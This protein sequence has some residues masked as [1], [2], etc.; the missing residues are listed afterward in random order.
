[1]NARE[2]F[3]APK[4]T[5]LRDEDAGL[6]P[7]REKNGG[8]NG[9]GG[10]KQRERALTS[11]LIGQVAHFQEMLFASR[12]QKLLLILQGMDTSGKDGTTRALFSESQ[13]SPMGL[14]ATGFVAPTE[15]ER[16][17]DFLWRVHAHVP[18]NG[19]IAVF[20]RSHY[21]DVLVPRVLG[22]IDG[23]ETK[24]RYAQIRDFERML[25]ETGTTI[26]KVFLHISKD[27][28]K[29]RLQERLDDPEK[30]WKFDPAD[31]AAREQWD[32]YQ[33]AYE[34]AINATNADHAPWYI[35]PAD[36]KTHRNLIVANLLLETMEDMKLSWPAPKADLDKV[37]VE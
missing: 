9:K 34:D 4:T 13:I 17:H 20:N 16:S 27:E 18:G 7:L 24:R 25:S 15:R 11:E 23:K 12:K 31:L 32:D 35:V 26:M 33:R 14:Q 6:T 29:Q 22:D 5:K 19:M 28:Q 21:E 3:R 1:M 2:R 37:K 8:E 30:H 36:S 10:N